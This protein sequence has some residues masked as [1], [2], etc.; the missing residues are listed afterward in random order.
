MHLMVTRLKRKGQVFEYAKIVQSYWDGKTSRQKVLVNLGRIRSPEDRRRF[1]EILESMRRGEKIMTVSINDVEVLNNFDF[2]VAYTLEKLWDAYGILRVLVEAFSNGRFEFDAVKIVRLLAA[3]RLHEPSSDLS[4]YEWILEEAFTDLKD[5]GPQHVY[6]TLDQLI[7][8]KEEVEV[9]IFKELQQKLGLK[10]DLVFYDL[11]S[12]YFEGE[13]PELAE[14]GKSRDHRPDRKQLVLALALI[15]GIPV[16]HE[17][18][19]GNTADKATLKHAVKKLKEKFDI[20]KIIF[21]ADRGVFSRENIDFL[22]E[23]GYEYIVAM[24]RRRDNE[25]GELMLTPIEA[26]KRVFAKE[27]KRE[28]NRRYILCL[29]RDIEREEREHLRELRQSLERKLKEFAESYTREGKGKKPSPENLIHKALNA[30]GKHRRL[31]NVKFDRGLKFSLKREAWDYENAIAGRFL[32]VT[33]SDLT[34]ERAM[35]AYKELC[36]IERAFR[37]IKDF[38]RIRPVYH[39][40]DRRVRA[41]VFVCVLSYLTEALI[42]RL[43]THQSARKTIQE[44]RRTKV[45]EIL[46]GEERIFSVRKMKS[47]D[48]EI[49]KSMGI[50]APPRNIEL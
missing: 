13:G 25:V 33:T 31:F 40:K 28:G 41:H 18:F 14:H 35:E 11:T 38:V 32:L 34:E 24:K 10:T 39:S 44:L 16:F 47:S 21:V 19:D 7:K 48:V 42:G 9:G 50:E 49:F 45:T 6:R 4:A 17:V 30:L 3:H 23:E 15:D 2:G 27:V 46:V 36:S 12:T 26:D 37:E 1:E 8:R 5:I 29:N 22:D 20:G 43:V